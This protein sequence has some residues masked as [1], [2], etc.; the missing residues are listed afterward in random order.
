[1]GHES[2]ALYPIAKCQ[3][4]TWVRP[5]NSMLF[6]E[7]AGFTGKNENLRKLDRESGREI[8]EIIL[9]CGSIAE[10]RESA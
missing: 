9:G 2:D 3:V 6:A 5:K 1:M 7:L 4:R 10:I 8:K